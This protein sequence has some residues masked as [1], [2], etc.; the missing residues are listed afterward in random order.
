MLHVAIILFVA[1][2]TAAILGYSGLATATVQTALVIFAIFLV[3]AA[4]LAGVG[5]LLVRT[6]ERRRGGAT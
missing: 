5:A 1:A 4:L 6:T 2:L 3:L